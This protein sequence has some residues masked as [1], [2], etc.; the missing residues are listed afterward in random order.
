MNYEKTESFKISFDLGTKYFILKVDL[1]VS[2]G[3]G[4]SASVI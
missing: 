3:L 2:L 1:S 4:F